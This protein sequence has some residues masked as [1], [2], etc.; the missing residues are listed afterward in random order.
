MSI[1]QNTFICFPLPSEH[2]SK[3]K[4][5]GIFFRGHYSVPLAFLGPAVFSNPQ[6][7]GCFALVAKGLVRHCE[8]SEE[9]KRT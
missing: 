7:R 5:R 2:L 3:G 4:T 8:V 6:V 9:V 1:N